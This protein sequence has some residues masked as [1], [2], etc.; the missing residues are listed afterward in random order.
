[1]NRDSAGRHT[2]RPSANPIR[3]RKVLDGEEKRMI[4]RALRR[5]HRDQRGFTLIELLVVI[6][7]LG[8]LAAIVTVS[9][10]GVT[11]TARKNALAA[12]KQ[13]VQT[14]FDAMLHDQHVDPA[15]LATACFNDPAGQP[16]PDSHFTDVMTNFPPKPP[17]GV[18]QDYTLPDFATAGKITV[19]AT[20]YLR[21][22]STRSA[23]YACD[24]VGN[25][26]QKLK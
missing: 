24:R 15:D 26:Y 5:L 8:V 25:I 3:P 16:P 21:E 14:A 1:M 9:L 13:T 2:V 18:A 10:L 17:T 7:I 12:E 4:L 19:L 23:K 20:H 22:T 11:S 6:T